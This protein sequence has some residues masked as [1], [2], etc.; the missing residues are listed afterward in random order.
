MRMLL[1]SIFRT[2][3]LIQFIQSHKSIFYTYPKSTL[4][5]PQN[6]TFPISYTHLDIIII[7]HKDYVPNNCFRIAFSSLLLAISF[8]TLVRFRLCTFNIQCTFS[9]GTLQ[10]HSS[11]S[12]VGTKGGADPTFASEKV[13]NAIGRIGIFKLA[14]LKIKAKSYFPSFFWPY[15]P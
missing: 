14:I 9:P 4:I 11:S 5:E 8:W 1:G 6:T 10:V 7:F 2:D 12:W 3:A 15:L 13:K